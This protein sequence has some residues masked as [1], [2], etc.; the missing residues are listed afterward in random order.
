LIKQ[1]CT[2]VSAFKFI[3]DETLVV[4][5]KEGPLVCKNYAPLWQK[6]KPC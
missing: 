4:E 6:E 2:G 1:N 5:W 3:L